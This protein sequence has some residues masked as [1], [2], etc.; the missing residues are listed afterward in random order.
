M[1]YVDKQFISVRQGGLM[2]DMGQENDG[3]IRVSLLIIK[4]G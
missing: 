1:F 2:S 3:V 4:I